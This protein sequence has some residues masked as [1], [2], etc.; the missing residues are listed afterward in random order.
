MNQTFRTASA[1]LRHTWLI[2][3]SYALAHEPLINA[4]LS[5]QYPQ[6]ELDKK[7]EAI[8][9][10]LA[11]SMSSQSR[12]RFAL[13]DP[14][15]P[16]NSV[17]VI[18]IK[19]AMFKEGFCG[20]AGSLDFARIIN[21]SY[22]NDKIIGSVVVWDCPGGQ[23]SGTPTLSDAIGNPQKPTVS[24]IHE[25]CMASAA[26]WAACPS[27]FI[28]ASQK[29]DQIGSIGVF[30][31]LRDTSEYDAKI[32]IKNLAIYSTRSPQKNKP[33]R[34]ALDGDNK[35]LEAELDETAVLFHEA[36]RAGRGDRLKPVK[37]DGPD[38]FEGGMFGASKAIEL[39]LIDGF[40]D[41]DAAIA[42]V[43]ELHEARQT[44]ATGSGTG[45][46]T[47]GP[48]LTDLSTHP[49]A[50][51]DA[52]KPGDNKP[53]D[54]LAAEGATQSNFPTQTPDNPMFGFTK[55][56]ALA[57][58]K[59]IA[60]ADVTAEQITAI[61]AE[62]EANGFPVATISETQ[63]AAAQ[64]LQTELTTANNNLT[65]ANSEVARLTAEVDRLGKQ[66][67]TTPTMTAK[68]EETL[69]PEA[70]VVISETDAELKRLKG[71]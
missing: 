19:G 28:M 4:F 39:G 42:K 67:G 11:G 49:L 48:Q 63:F 3:E 64:T 23:V 12:Q 26:Y 69:A 55:L 65:T 16:D 7:P 59:G 20:S 31:R 47:D 43:V 25:G 15:M 29:T 56:P 14:D 57:A 37:K 36:V 30:V 10:A 32:G 13:D 68:T 35:A 66:P 50:S 61:N 70:D 60:S 40:G 18:E 45:A 41:L 8:G 54:A 34:D 71:N 17:L 52:P 53:T 1:L 21:D 6:A 58:V 27:D 38:V 24:V 44:T 5:G 2:D 62:L 22:A 51:L 46:S 9:F 33:F